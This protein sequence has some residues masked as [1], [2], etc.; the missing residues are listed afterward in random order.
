[1]R[2][3]SLEPPLAQLGRQGRLR[4]TTAIRF[5]TGLWIVAPI[6]TQRVCRVLIFSVHPLAFYCRLSAEGLS[7][8]CTPDD[9]I[10][11]S[12]TSPPMLLWQAPTRRRRAGRVTEN[13]NCITPGLVKGDG[14]TVGRK[15]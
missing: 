4:S 1:M 12:W 14:P 15:E 13:V 8:I 2:P 9:G 10:S 11:E 6:S 7:E 5:R 3:G